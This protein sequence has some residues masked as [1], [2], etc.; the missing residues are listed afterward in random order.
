MRLSRWHLALLV[1]VAF[2]AGASLTYAAAPAPNVVGTAKFPINVKAG[3]YDLMTQ[4]VDLPPGSMVPKHM[5]GGPVVVQVL[6]GAVTL[7]D[8]MGTR[9]FKTGG[10]WTENPGVPHSAANNGSTPVR[11][12]VAYLIPQGAEVITF[13]K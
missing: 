11:V 2:A 4:V 13:V 10:T 9:I 12:A 7:T 3:D 6:T 1:L 5:H 8:S